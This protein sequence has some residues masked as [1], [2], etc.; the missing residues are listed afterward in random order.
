[1]SIENNKIEVNYRSAASQFIHMKYVVGSAN[2]SGNALES[3]SEEVLLHLR[4]CRSA[5]LF[6][7]DFRYRWQQSQDHAVRGSAAR[8]GLTLN[9]SATFG[10]PPTSGRLPP[11]PGAAVTER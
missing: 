9:H 10:E 3:Y 4:G 6:E 1:M 7:E 5:S 11:A 8:S 2:F